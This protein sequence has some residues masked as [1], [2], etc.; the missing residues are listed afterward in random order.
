MTSLVDAIAD[1]SSVSA[2]GEMSGPVSLNDIIKEVANVFDHS[3]KEK[4][5]SLEISVLPVVKANRLH[6][7]QLFH[8]LLSNSLKYSHP[9][10]APVIR[11]SAREVNNNFTEVTLS[12]NGLGFDNV[13]ALKVFEP[14]Q[15]LHGKEFQGTGIGL[16]ICKKIIEAHGGTIHVESYKGAGTTFTFTLPLS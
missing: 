10:I 13:H 14:F 11:V 4:K 15:R 9:H 5:A 16:A 7:Y 2:S 12:D 6:L 8:N 3:I 1:L